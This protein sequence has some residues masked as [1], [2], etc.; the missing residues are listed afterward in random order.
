MHHE[1]LQAD[2]RIASGHAPPRGARTSWSSFIPCIF[3]LLLT[4]CGGGGGGVVDV[5]VPVVTAP[6]VTS[7]PASVSVAAGAQASFSVVATGNVL[8]Y[9]WLRSV[10]NG[11][12]WVA[13]DGASNRSFT[14]DSVDATMDGDQYR[15]VM[16]NAVGSALSSPAT[17]TVTVGGGGGGGGGV[18]VACVPPNVLPVG[19]VVRTTSSLD[20]GGT[21]GTPQVATMTVVGPTTFQGRSVFETRIETA[22]LLPGVTRAFT[23]WDPTSGQLTTWGAIG[24]YGSGTTFADFT[25]VVR[26]PA[27]YPVYA[28]AAG[29]STTATAV[30]DS[31]QVLT[32][33]GVAGTPQ[34][35]SESLT[36]TYT[37]LGT[38]TLTVPAGTFLTCKLRQQAA[39]AAQ[40]TTNWL[41]AGYGATVKSVTPTTTQSLTAI[42]V[43]GAPLTQFP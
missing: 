6:V 13:V 17:L 35:S 19:M 9:Q 4:A 36:T 20:V 41:M 15:V 24:R 3:A 28:L 18:P 11:L 14:I 26:Q 16:Q 5:P 23:T 7:Q 29:Q 25:T 39:G 22:G 1:P 32:T 38:E 37:F 42:T 43:N 33:N 21:P 34:T 8:V 10:N 40:P 12:S 31:T 27:Q 30:S 2:T